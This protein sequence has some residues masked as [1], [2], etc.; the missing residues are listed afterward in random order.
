MRWRPSKAFSLALSAAPLHN[1]RL[2]ST[3]SPLTDVWIEAGFRWATESWLRA[4][5]PEDDDRLYYDEKQV[6]AELRW[7]PMV[8]L[9][10]SIGAGYA[11]GREWREG[12]SL[13]D[14]D[15]F[16]EIDVASSAFAT[17]GVTVTLG[18]SDP[19]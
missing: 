12:D 1:V 14:D 17:L 9:R 4:D 3:W 2:I 19:P 10:V 16:N 5:R 7:R 11:F 18:D 8:A 13:T 6:A 15:A